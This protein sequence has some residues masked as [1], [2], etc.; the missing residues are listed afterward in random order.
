MARRLPPDPYKVLGVPRNATQ[1]DLRVAWRRLLKTLNPDKELDPMRRDQARER[2]QQVVE[3]Y[4]LLTDP[5]RL[6]QYNWLLRL[7]ELRREPDPKEEPEEESKEKPEE[8][9]KEKP[10]EEPEEEFEEAPPPYR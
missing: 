10:E 7:E 3:A 2:F 4:Q 5:Q 1:S 6:S 9:P 8:N